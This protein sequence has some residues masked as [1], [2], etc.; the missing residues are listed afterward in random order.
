MFIWLCRC[1]LCCS[2]Y[3]K[4]K[5][6]AKI[7]N[8]LSLSCSDRSVSS[9]NSEQ[10]SCHFWVSVF[11]CRCLRFSE[12]FCLFLPW[13][14]II[15]ILVFVIC[16]HYKATGQWRPGSLSDRIISSFELLSL[17]YVSFSFRV[18]ALQS[19]EY[20]FTKKIL[21]PGWCISYCNKKT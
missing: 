7:M 8:F 10:P 14:L 20:S 2:F 3:I 19:I 6:F 18:L 13:C 12:L 21:T 4:E 17:H 5:Y 11:K 15:S 1:E 16:L 9:V